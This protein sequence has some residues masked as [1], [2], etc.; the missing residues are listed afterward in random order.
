[1]TLQLGD[2]AP[3]FQ[4][5][6]TA[7]DIDFYEWAGDSWVIFFSHPADYTPVCTTEL[8]TVARYKDD[9]E[10]RGVKTIAIS[11]DGIDDHHG[12]VKDIE[13]TQDTSVE[14]P[15][16]ADEDKSV[17]NAYGMIHPKADTTATVRSVFIIDPDKKIRLTLT[18]PA[19]TGRNFKELLRVIDALQL[20]DNHKV[21]TPANWEQGDDVIIVPSLKDEEEIARRFPK[22]YKEIKPYLRVTPQPDKA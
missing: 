1:M 3:N 19:A 15:I 4:A 12:W 14:F 7:G 17:A 22:G 5:T 10:K 13:E 20:T 18:Y 21:A 8:G 11:V 6:T 9:F 16:V 2:T